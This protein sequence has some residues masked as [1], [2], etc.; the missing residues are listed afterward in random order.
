M[1]NTEIEKQEIKVEY[2]QTTAVSLKR[3]IKSVI[4]SQ[5]N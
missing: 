2:Q 4:S 3:P 1:E 5:T